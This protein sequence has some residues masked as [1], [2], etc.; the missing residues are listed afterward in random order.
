MRFIFLS[1]LKDLRRLCHDPL[2]PATWVAAPL[3]VGVLLVAFFGH[4]QAKP[5]GLVLIADQDKT[6]LSALILHAYTQD[7]LGEMF[8]VQ[9]VP[10]QEG[11]Q[12]IN[13]GDGS[14]LVIIPKGLSKAVLGKQKA[15]IQ[16]ITNPSQ[17]ILPNIVE[18]V[19][20]ILVEG[21][22]RLQQLTGDDLYQFSG[23]EPPSDEDIA[24]RSVRF[25]HLF[26]DYRK[27]LDPPAIKVTVEAVEL[28][29]HRAQ[30]NMS[31]AMFPT[32]TFLALM[33]VAFG[34]ANDIWKEKMNG[35]LRHV[36]VTR[37]SLAGFLGGKILALWTVF[38]LV[39]VIAL[40]SGKFL[41]GSESHNPVLAVLWLAVSGGAMYMLLLFLS[42]FFSNPRGATT[43]SNLLV[44]TLSMLGGCFFPL[45]L[46]PDSLARIGRWTPNGLALQF[47]RNILTGQFNHIGLAVA[48]AAVLGFTV[49]LLAGAA[50]QLRWKFIF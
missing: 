10:L 36:A 32:M 35:T 17:F 25:S 21:V 3:I 14:A 34:M 37:G 7:K 1:A 12:L 5:Q 38:A 40:L 6:I 41:I 47:F 45:D 48:F 28:N 31:E 49:R 2:T 15:K 42:T 16:L 44:M 39:G 50:R 43:I 9:Q 19:T 27:Y 20:S 8:T 33:F 11:Q 22:W 29:P 4:Q 18:S 13:S 46:M 30:L 26:T 24:K 23:D